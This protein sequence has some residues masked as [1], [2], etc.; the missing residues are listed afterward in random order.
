MFRDWREKLEKLNKAV[1]ASK[2]KCRLFTSKEFLT[3]LAIII[4]AAEFAR[5]GCDLFSVKDQLVDDDDD[6]DNDA[7]PSLCQDP[8]FEQYMPFSRYLR[9]FFPEIFV[10]EG[11]KETDPWYRFS[12][13]ID[14]FNSLCQSEVLCSK[15]I[16]IDETMSAWKPRKTA[17]GGLPNISF[18]VRKPEPLG[19]TLRTNKHFLHTYF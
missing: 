15:W 19:K 1:L 3:G 18:I 7:W 12:S 5:R 10:D 17:L 13:A 11:K 14:E 4:G 6:D 2:S 8:H 16:S 9:R